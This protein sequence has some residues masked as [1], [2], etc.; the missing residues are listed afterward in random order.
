MEET[1]KNTLTEES[2][3]TST[4]SNETSEDAF[5][6]AVEEQLKKVHRQGML[7]GAQTI[8]RVTLEKIVAFKSKPGKPTMNDYKRLIKDIQQFCETGLSRKVNADGETEPVEESSEA[9]TVQ[10]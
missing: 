1:I 9:E 7:I 5:K 3:E 6:E 8:F 10:N 4:P 2:N